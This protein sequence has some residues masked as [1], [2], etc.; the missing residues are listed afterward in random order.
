M[1]N[2]EAILEQNKPH[3]MNGLCVCDQCSWPAH[4]EGLHAGLGGK[5]LLDTEEGV[6]DVGHPQPDDIFLE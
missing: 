6:L 4:L 1:R 2:E 3:P 5:D